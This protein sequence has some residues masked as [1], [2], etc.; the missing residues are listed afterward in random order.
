[1]VTSIDGQAIQSYGE[2]VAR[3]RGHKSGD[4][5]TLGV[6]RGGNET[7]ITATLAQRPAG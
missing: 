2:L 1:V 5:V 7:T 3:I 6:T 4:E